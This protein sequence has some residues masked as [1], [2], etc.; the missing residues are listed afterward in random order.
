MFGF[1]RDVYP[2]CECVEFCNNTSNR[3]VFKESEYESTAIDEKGNEYPAWTDDFEYRFPDLDDPYRD[4]TQ[5]KRLTDWLVSC[6]RELVDTDEE[7][8]ARL[9]KFKDEFDQY[10]IKDAC[11][12]YYLF[13]EIF[14]M[15]DN[16]AKNMFLTTF[17]GEHW[18]PIPY[19]WDT[20]IG[21]VRCLLDPFR[22]ISGVLACQS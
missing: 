11:V 1:D 8:A 12:F 15:V 4:Y 6:N 19:D 17:D 10:L 22:L 14:L 20:A 16:R 2:H 21:I 3:V 7:K 13:T 18:F 9:Q 5:F